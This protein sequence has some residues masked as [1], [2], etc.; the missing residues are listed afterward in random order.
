MA[1]EKK[2]SDKIK[3]Y[4][5]NNL[6]KT[7]SFNIYDVCYAKTD[8]EKDEYVKYI[9][10]QYNADRLTNILCDVSDMIGAHV[11]NISKQDYDPQGAS[12]TVLIAEMPIKKEDLDPSCNGAYDI[13]T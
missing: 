6:T 12:V 13:L 11:L 5:F 2:I 3:L 9:D 8:R 7:L 10:D 4:G 1:E